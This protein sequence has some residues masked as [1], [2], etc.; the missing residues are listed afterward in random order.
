V[1]GL[2]YTKDVKAWFEDVV[3]I[4]ARNLTDLERRGRLKE[5]AKWAWFAREFRSGLERSNPLALKSWGLSLDAI[6]WP[7]W[8]DT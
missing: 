7:E 2:S 4:I 6:P 5:L 8:Q 3:G 1:P